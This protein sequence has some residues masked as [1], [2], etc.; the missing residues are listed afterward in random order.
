MS[1]PVNYP[2]ANLLTISLSDLRNGSPSAANEVVRA[3]KQ[4]GVFYLEF[5]DSKELPYIGIIRN[6]QALSRELFQLGLDQKMKFDVDQLGPFKSNGY[7]RSSRPP[8]HKLMDGLG[9]SLS[10]A[11]SGGSQVRVMDLKATP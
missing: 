8:I 10:V 2:I 9:T 11:T 1:Q 7:T 4:D 6:I 5:T 3:A